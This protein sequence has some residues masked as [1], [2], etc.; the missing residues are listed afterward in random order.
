M[1]L[2]VLDDDAELRTMP[3]R[4]ETRR[5]LE[6]D[7]DRGSLAADADLEATHTAI[8]SFTYGYLVY[9]EALAREFGM[10]VEELDERI[11][12][13]FDRMLR[14]LAPMV[15]SSAPAEPVSLAAHPATPARPPVRWTVPPH[16]H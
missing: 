11:A 13:V 12:V 6:A 3:L 7:R 16:G 9:R 10:S 8:V 15:A 4:H 2:L 5:L 14:G 1:T